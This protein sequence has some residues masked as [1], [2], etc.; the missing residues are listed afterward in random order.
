MQRLAL[1][2]VGVAVAVAGAIG[3]LG[4]SYPAMPA[5]TLGV[6]YAIGAHVALTSDHVHAIAKGQTPTF[7]FHRKAQGPSNKYVWQRGKIERPCLYRET[8]TGKGT[9]GR[10]RSCPDQDRTSVLGDQLYFSVEPGNALRIGVSDKPLENRTVT[11]GA[12]YEAEGEIGIGK[13]AN[14]A[15][16]FKITL[17][18]EWLNVLDPLVPADRNT[19][20]DWHACE[21]ATRQSLRDPLVLSTLPRVAARPCQITPE[22]SGR[23]LFLVH[24]QSG[25][26]Q[27]TDWTNRLGCRA[28][29]HRLMPSPSPGDL[30]GCI[31]GPWGGFDR[32]D[33]ALAFFEVTPSGE[34]AVIR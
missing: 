13:S 3:W 14:D 28:L 8:D 1:A 33:L 19:D 4:L 27:W 25:P 6:A 9:L 30:A 16:R 17:D 2:I 11:N 20:P 18:A 15:A 21:P 32:T 29:L 34:F 23:S 22:K 24:F 10:T 12:L 26:L 5:S 31:G 7:E